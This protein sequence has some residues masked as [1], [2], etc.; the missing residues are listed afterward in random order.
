MI[1]GDTVSDGNDFIVAQ[2]LLKDTTCSYGG[3]VDTGLQEWVGGE[4]LLYHDPC[5]GEYVYSRDRLTAGGTV[6][7]IRTDA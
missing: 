5:T 6:F 7:P 3:Y 2:G 1:H 4:V